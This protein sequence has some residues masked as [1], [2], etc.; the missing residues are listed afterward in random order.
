MGFSTSP[1]VLPAWL[2]PRPHGCSLP[3][4]HPL[5]IPVSPGRYTCHSQLVLQLMR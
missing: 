4:P 3:L 2:D 1:R 5:E